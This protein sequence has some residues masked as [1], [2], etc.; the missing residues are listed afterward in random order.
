MKKDNLLLREERQLLALL[1]ASVTGHP[2]RY[3]NV[4]LGDEIGDIARAHA[5][6]SL[7]FETVSE[8][9]G[10]S[11]ALYER[12]RRDTEQITLQSYRL[13]FET[14]R[15]CS[16]LENEGVRI[17]VLK[18]AAVSS[19]YPYPEYRKS[20]DIDILLCDID[21]KDKVI[22]ML[23]NDGYKISDY[24]PALHQIVLEGKA[25]IEIELHVLLAEPFDNDR[26]N[27]Y[28]DYLV[29]DIAEHIICWEV[30]GVDLPILDD[31]YQ[32]YELLLHML[33]HFLRRGFGLKLLCD[34]VAYWNDRFDNCRPDIAGEYKRLVS[35]SGLSGFSDMITGICY[36]YLGLSEKALRG[37]AID[38]NKNAIDRR[39]AALFMREVLDGG[40]FGDLEKD[41]MVMLR[42]TSLISYIREFH[43]QMKLNF[44]EAGK[45]PVAWPALWSYTLGKFIYNNI[46]KRHTTAAN[47]LKKSG[48]RSRIMKQIRLWEK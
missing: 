20:G 19:F 4:V 15:I 18:G 29:P 9:T 48:E 5:V 32:A 25:G 41:R 8:C 27:N 24:Q 28:M 13:L 40:E 1:K 46:N 11:G 2:D 16:L 43:H 45:Y 6:S 37:L 35:E 17:A 22:S 26:I 42:D 33:Q 21:K 44:P 47:I 7:I 39:A 36:T 30:M 23:K 34:W 14:R 10:K 12:I 31:K 3:K 38:V